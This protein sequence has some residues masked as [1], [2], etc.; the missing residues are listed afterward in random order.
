M[1]RH[2]HVD[3]L[4]PADLKEIARVRDSDS[5][6]HDGSYPTFDAYCRGEWQRSAN[7]INKRLKRAG[8]GSKR[9]R[10]MDRK[11]ERTADWIS[12]KY[13]ALKSDSQ[14]HDRVSPS[15]SPKY[16]S[17]SPSPSNNSSNS[18]EKKKQKEEVDSD[19][20]T[21]INTGDLG[22]R[23]EAAFKPPATPPKGKSSW[24]G[25]KTME[26]LDRMFEE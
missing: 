8:K 9:T 5:Y 6:I 17:V 7:T 2:E 26:E 3:P 16:E 18:S 20:L 12:A 11:K 21:K 1:P 15:V 24:G 13:H 25:E 23:S 10:K 14:S 19:K 4:Y 22:T